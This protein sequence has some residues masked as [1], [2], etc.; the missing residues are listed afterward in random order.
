MPLFMLQ[1][2]YAPSAVRA[3]VERP[4]DDQAAAPAS[5]VASLGGRLVGYWFALGE[6]DGVAIIEA[7]DSSVA[8]A[9]TMA[10]G[11]TGHVRRIETTVLM[12]MD[13]AQSAMRKAASATHLPPREDAER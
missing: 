7:A 1:F 2:S 11:S 13:E 5:L 12:T 3:F 10:I 4:A 8:A 9:V 6:F